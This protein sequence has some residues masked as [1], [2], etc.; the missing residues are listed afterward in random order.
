MSFFLDR[1][2]DA[3]VTTAELINEN[4][5]LDPASIDEVVVININGWAVNDEWG[6]IKV[7]MNSRD[8]EVEVAGVDGMIKVADGRAVDLDNSGDVV[9]G[10]NLA[11][12]RA[13]SIWV[14]GR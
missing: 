4:V 7:V 8:T 10:N 11:A 13:V 2:F 12:A 5:T 9:A 3:A 6:T 14:T 1:I